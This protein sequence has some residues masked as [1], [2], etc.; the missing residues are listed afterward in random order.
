MHSDE[1]LFHL[2]FKNVC[3]TFLNYILLVYN[4]K[5]AFFKF[6]K[7]LRTSLNEMHV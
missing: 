2:F 3:L 5:R 6:F 4:L 7:T 1:I